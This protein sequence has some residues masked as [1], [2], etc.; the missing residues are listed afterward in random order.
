MLISA[1]SSILLGG[2]CATLGASLGLSHDQMV[3]FA[4]AAAPVILA[5]IIGGMTFVFKLLPK[6]PES[7]LKSAAE[8]PG[9]HGIIADDAVANSPA[10]QANPKIVSNAAQLPV[11]V[12]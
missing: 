6:S 8:Q 2:A 7:I 9:V 5:A 11:R 4:N 3:N 12:Q 10:L 1:I